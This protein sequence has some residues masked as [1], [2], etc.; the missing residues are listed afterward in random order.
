MRLCLVFTAILVGSIFSNPLVPVSDSQK[1][2]ESSNF[3]VTVTITTGS[4]TAKNTCGPTVFIHETDGIKTVQ[5]GPTPAPGSTYSETVF[6]DYVVNPF[7]IKVSIEASCSVGL[8]IEAIYVAGYQYQ[9]VSSNFG[10]SSSFSIDGDANGGDKLT[11]FYCVNGVI[12]ELCYSC[13]F[14]NSIMSK[15]DSMTSVGTYAV[16][17]FIEVGSQTTGDTKCGMVVYIENV[18]D[19]I[20]PVK[21]SGTMKSGGFY[22]QTVYVD[23]PMTPENMRVMVSATPG[24]TDGVDVGKIFVSGYQYLLQDQVKGNKEEFWIDGDDNTYDCQNGVVCS[25]CYDC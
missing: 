9:L 15:S 14:P 1:P 17:V 19:G 25:L 10:V 18:A 23:S 7:N 3:A 11:N 13:N 21:F 16:T 22:T 20:I 24:C 4:N 6:V 12:C 2:S 8:E 5:F